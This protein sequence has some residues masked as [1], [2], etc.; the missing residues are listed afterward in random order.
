MVC[1]VFFT[2]DETDESLSSDISD[3]KDSL[4][5]VSSHDEDYHLFPKELKEK[6]DE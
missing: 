2:V 5:S 6:V 1:L 3:D 4:S